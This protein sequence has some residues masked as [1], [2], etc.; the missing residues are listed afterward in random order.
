MPKEKTDHME[1]PQE[2][3]GDD[4]SELRIKNE[5][6]RLLP[7]LPPSQYRA[8]ENSILENGQLEP[9]IANLEKIVID[10][11]NRLKICRAHNIKPKYVVREFANEL[12]EMKF[13]IE[14]NL[15]RRQLTTF[16]RIEMALPLIEIERKLAEKRKKE[17]KSPKDLPQNFGE[18]GE[19]L[20]IVAE[21]IGVSHETVRRAL[22]LIEHAQE[23]E[24][25]KLRAGE[26]SIHRLYVE[27]KAKKEETGSGMPGFLSRLL[28]RYP[29]GGNGQ[30]GSI[31]LK[32]NRYGNSEF[33]AILV[34]RSV[35][36]KFARACSRVKEELG[37]PI[38]LE[39]VIMD[40]LEEYWH[41]FNRALQS[42]KTTKSPQGE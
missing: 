17:G 38:D 1:I 10:G 9:I 28:K 41:R 4:H 24:L 26:K 39:L 14:T 21:R 35:I 32:I 5:Y 36:D 40:A 37:R 23:E 34:D 19:T 20:K 18:G 13:I 31:K 7:P 11:L 6:K 33:A 2:V 22:W 12:E 42:I 30:S 8:L 16:Q 27:L 3:Y 25:D 29:A 15:M